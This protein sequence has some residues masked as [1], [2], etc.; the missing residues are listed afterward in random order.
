L[1]HV[2]TD[3]NVLISSV[4]ERDREERERTQK[5]V[6]RA[7]TGELVIVLPQFVIFESIFVFSS[8]YKLLPHEIA[9]LIREV[10]ALPG[11]TI[12]DDCPWQ[13]FFEYW[14]DVR[15]DVVDSALLAVSI[16][17]HYSLA[18]F[19]RKLSNRAKTFGVA[20]YW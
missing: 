15:P 10:I 20:P 7:E 18:T 12:V 2:I 16:A 8:V 6:L 1:L 3:T 9:I 5:L 19:D 17:N 13:Q 14:S 4:L 11:V